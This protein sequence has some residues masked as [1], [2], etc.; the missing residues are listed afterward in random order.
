MRHPLSSRKGVSEIIAVML[1]IVI[2][3]AA[4]VLMYVYVSGLMGRLQGVVVQQPYLEQVSMDYYDWS[5]SLSLTL[6]KLNLTLRNV[7][8]AKVSMSDF[9]IAGTRNT[10]ALTFGSGCNTPRGVLAVQ[11][12]CVVTFP[13]P[14]GLTPT[15]G[16]AYSVKIVSKDGAIFSFSCI[17]GQTS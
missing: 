17:A 4:S 3:V 6:S 2:A 11:V 5:P 8:V 13:M 14:T 16:L 7:G 9:F 15:S 12:S 1:L 10:T